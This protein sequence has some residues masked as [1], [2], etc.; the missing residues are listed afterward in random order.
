MSLYNVSVEL[1]WSLCIAI[2][3]KDFVPSQAFNLQNTKTKIFTMP[4][5]LYIA[6][7]TLISCHTES[8]HCQ[9]PGIPFPSPSVFGIITCHL[10]P[11]E[12]LYYN[13][14]P[15]PQSAFYVS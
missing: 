1:C 10:L 9:L 15:L 6:T 8:C 2:L 13:L 3:I 4:V 5:R 12:N 14:V 11:L 7:D